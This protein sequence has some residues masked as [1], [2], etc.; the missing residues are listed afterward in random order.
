MQELGKV[1][2][3]GLYVIFEKY[4]GLQLLCSIIHLITLLNNNT[5]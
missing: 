2:L 5:Q 4:L 1:I 3:L